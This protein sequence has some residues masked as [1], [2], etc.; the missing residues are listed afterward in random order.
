MKAYPVYIVNHFPNYNINH[1]LHYFSVS[2][3]L[4]QLWPSLSHIFR[5]SDILPLTLNSYSLILAWLQLHKCYNITTLWPSAIY[6]KEFTVF[7][8][9]LR[10]TSS[11]SIRGPL[12][13]GGEDDSYYGYKLRIFELLWTHGGCTEIAAPVG[14]VKLSGSTGTLLIQICF[15]VAPVQ[16][17]W[18][19]GQFWRFRPDT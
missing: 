3:V 14:I 10:V 4:I 18:I 7:L 13:S 9:P 19:M 16:L 15:V 17:W 12:V 8:W 1:L 5:F 6:N 2:G 11:Q